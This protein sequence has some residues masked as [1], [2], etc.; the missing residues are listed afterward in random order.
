MAV[1]GYTVT[2]I[3]VTAIAQ[4]PNELSG[5]KSMRASRSNTPNFRTTCKQPRIGRSLGGAH[6]KALVDTSEPLVQR[7]QEALAAHALTV[8]EPPLTLN[9]PHL[10][11][12]SSVTLLSAEQ[13][14]VDQRLTT[15]VSLALSG[16]DRLVV[17]GPNGAGKSTLLQVLAQDLKPSSGNVERQ[18]RSE[19]RRVGKAGRS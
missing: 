11:S 13:A 7:R 15:P 16:G 4:L 9:F 10:T 19:E 6:Q 3:R 2:A 8:P 18:T 5:N 1:H 12:R 14:T 17:T